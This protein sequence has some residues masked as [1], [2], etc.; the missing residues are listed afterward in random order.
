MLE[1]EV[2][3]DVCCPFT[4]VG[5]RRVVD[6]RHDLGRDEPRLYVRA[7]PLELANGMPLDAALIGE[8][9]DELRRQV[10]PDLFRG[11]DRSAFPHSSLPAFALAAAAY[12]RDLPTG[13]AVSLEL[14]AALFEQGRDVSDP[15]VLAAIATRHDLRS[16]DDADR[17]RAVEDWHDGQA[18]GV[19]GSPHFFLATGDFFCPTLDISR[20]NGQLRITTDEESIATFIDA[21]LRP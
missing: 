1:I 15:D 7:W 21:A 14:R 4:H 6:R 12:Q 5:L 3:A 11:F 10:A 20:D 2:F 8:E 17:H 16:P 13:E 18:R 9:V 19:V